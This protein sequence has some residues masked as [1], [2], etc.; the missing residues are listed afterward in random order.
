MFIYE[1]LPS[2]IFPLLNGLNIFCLTSQHASPG[3]Q[4]VFTNIFGGTN[5]NEGL[6]LFSLGFDWQYIGSVYVHRV[7]N[8]CRHAQCINRFMSLPLIQQ[9]NTWVGIALS[10][11]VLAGIYYSNTWNE[12]IIFLVCKLQLIVFLT[13]KVISNALDIAILF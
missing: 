4:D 13:V 6:G 10:Y 3:V 7:C 5:A 12:S 11:V 9:A 1:I 2:Y 8:L